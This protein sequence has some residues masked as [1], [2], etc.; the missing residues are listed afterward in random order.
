MAVDILEYADIENLRYDPFASGGTGLYSPKIIG[1]GINPVETRQIPNSSP[2]IV[3][4]FEAPQEN[5]PS[6][7]RITRVVGSVVMTEVAKSVP[8]SSNQ[9][10]VTYFDELGMGMVEFNSA[11]A[12]EE[13]EIEYYGL[14]HL[15]QK[16]EGIL[17]TFVPKVGNTTIT[18]DIT[19]DGDFD[20]DSNTFFVNSS[21]SRVGVNTTSPTQ[22]LDIRSFIM[23]GSDNQ[24]NN[25]IKSFRYTCNHYT[26]AE[27]PLLA[28]I[29]TSQAAS[30][31]VSVGGGSGLIN[32][33]TEISFYTA[34]NT[35]TT[36]GTKRGSFDTNGIFEVDTNLLYVTPVTNRVGVGTV[37]PLK[38]MHVSSASS[39]AS[40]IIERTSSDSGNPTLIFKKSRNNTAVLSGDDLGQIFVSPVYDGIGTSR[41]L[42]TIRIEAT[43]NHGGSAAGNRLDFFTTANGATSAS[44]RMRIDENGYVGIG[45]LIPFQKLDIRDEIMTGANSETNNAAKSFQYTSLHYTNAQEPFG[46]IRGVSGASD[47]D[48][49]IG[50][51][52]ATVNAA[53]EIHMYTAVNNTTTTGT[54]VVTITSTLRMGINETSPSRAL[55]V[56][57]VILAQD[58]YEC[59][60]RDD[61][62]SE[63]IAVIKTKIIEIGDWNMDTTTSLSVAHNITNWKNIRDVSAIIR[64]DG[65]TAYYNLFDSRDAGGNSSGGMS[66]ID[67][68]NILLT[69]VTGGLFDGIG[70]DSTSYNRGWIYVV[71]E[72]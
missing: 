40:I 45:T 64:N 59:E 30:S 72:N 62:P 31:I 52:A 35:T 38:R 56:D 29:G 39:E 37:S 4:L 60:Y 28:I 15:L 26:N 20:V 36:T 65:D 14:G 21:T 11:Q 61:T 69:R 58:G 66:S 43:E 34:A 41:D 63:T 12:G 9:Y 51:G 67:S 42:S 13:I 22:A 17:N 7:T 24:T 2:Y 49:H 18:G 3:R 54:E 55:D 27:E 6:T 33:A 48:L 10:R 32:A 50:G 44:A 8:P 53:T 57:G 19:I 16:D 47:N 25:T 23:S 68:T 1:Y 46:L 70:Y 71:Y 5:L